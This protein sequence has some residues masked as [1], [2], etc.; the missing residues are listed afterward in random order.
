MWPLI[1]LF[2]HSAGICLLQAVHEKK[3][4]IEYLPSG[5]RNIITLNTQDSPLWSILLTF[6]Q[7]TVALV[8]INNVCIARKLMAVH[9]AEV[10]LEPSTEWL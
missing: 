10:D 8:G 5:F 9:M 1:H 6:S 7:E 2:T 4:V 3:S